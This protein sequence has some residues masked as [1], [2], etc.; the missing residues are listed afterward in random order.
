MPSRCVEATTGQAATCPDG[1]RATRAESSRRK[2]TRSSARML[3]A[4]LEG[5]GT[6]LGSVDEP[7]ALAVVPAARGLQD[8]RA[9]PKRDSTSA[10]EETSALRGQGTPSSARRGPHHALVLGVHQ[11]VGPGPHGQVRLERV[12][13]VG[14]HVLVVEGDHLA[15]GGDLAQRGQVGVVA[16]HVVGDHL[17]CAHPGRLGEQPQRD[18]QRRGGFGHHPGQLAAT[19]HGHDRSG[20]WS[21]RGDPTEPST[22]RLSGRAYDGRPPARGHRT[23]APGGPAAPGS[24]TCRSAAA[25]PCAAS[26]ITRLRRATPTSRAA[27]LTAGP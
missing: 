4:G 21:S 8:A 13:V 22:S 6:V 1:E 10:T 3:G 9:S 11:R 16:H 2:S 7:D 23:R 14:G 25:R 19:D 20:R 18:A 17:G 12:Q 15:A 26:V 27:R 24:R 5:G